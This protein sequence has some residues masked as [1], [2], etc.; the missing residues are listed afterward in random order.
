MKDWFDNDLYLFG[1]I[2]CLC[3]QYYSEHTG[4]SIFGYF[5]T[6]KDKRFSTSFCVMTWN[7]NSSWSESGP[8]DTWP[9]EMWMRSLLFMLDPWN[10]EEVPDVHVR[11]LKCSWCVIQAEYVWISSVSY[12]DGILP[13]GPYPPCLC[14]ADRAFF[15]GYPR[16]MSIL[17][18]G[19]GS[20]SCITLLLLELEAH[21][22]GGLWA[23]DW[24]QI[25]TI[26][27]MTFEI[28]IWFD[29]NLFM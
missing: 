2:S 7:F 13:K 21:F 5:I 16:C 24:N 11:S 8:P 25:R 23:Y 20:L 19:V 28:V 14:M 10:V 12:V 29:H 17:L 26:P 1:Q 3:R 27:I 22:T 6:K 15:A 9:R 18:F 4:G